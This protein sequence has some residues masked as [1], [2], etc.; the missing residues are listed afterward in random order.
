MVQGRQRADL[1]Y[2]YETAA[3]DQKAAIL[4]QISQLDPGGVTY[5]PYA[6]PRRLDQQQLAIATSGGSAPSDPNSAAA[7]PVS[8]VIS[9][10]TDANASAATRLA[11]RP[12]LHLPVQT[13]SGFLDNLARQLR[14]DGAQDQATRLAGFASRLPSG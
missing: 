11:P 7:D 4:L 5:G 3:S 1:V 13:V 10:I 2:G 9:I 14:Q 6:Q 8:R 12:G